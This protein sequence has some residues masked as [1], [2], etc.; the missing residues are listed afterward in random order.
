MR[1]LLSVF[2]LLLSS[3]VLAGAEYDQLTKG[4][5]KDAIKIIDR[6]IGCTYWRG[7]MPSDANT[8]E[9]KE[10]GRPQMIEKELKKLRCSHLD[11]DEKKTKDKYKKNE[12]VL[13][14]LNQAGGMSPAD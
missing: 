4:L 14:S 13:N 11:D 7:E 9:G 8:S 1:C 10:S 2:L 3:N 6:R 5:P 12:K